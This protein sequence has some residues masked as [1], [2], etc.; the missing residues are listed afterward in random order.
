MNENI[1]FAIQ[2]GQPL[3]EL[4]NRFPALMANLFEVLIAVI[5]AHFSG[6]A[7][8]PLATQPTP[9]KGI[10]AFIYFFEPF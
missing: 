8:Q 1:Y 4:S 9:K 2:G 3:S 10:F 5:D 7:Q 6:R